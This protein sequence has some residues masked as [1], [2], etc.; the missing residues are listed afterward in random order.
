V[1]LRG[2]GA[3]GREV[4]HARAELVLMPQLPAAP[5]GVLEV[6]TRPYPH[7]QTD[8]YPG[9]LFHGADLQGIE[10]VEGCATEGVVGRVA[11]AP[12]P[13][14]WIRQPLRPNWLADPLAL[15]S[16]FQLMVVWSRAAHG[17]PSLPCFAGEYRQYRRSFPRGGVR[18]VCRVTLNH[19][20]RAQ[21]DIDFVDPSGALVARMRDYECTLDGSLTEAFRRHQLP[22]LALPTT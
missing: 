19:P 14:A 17:V 1:E 10:L 22:Q 4:L 8:L 18:V 6:A 20:H 16:A 15:D 13:A 7:T 21:A 9:L 11:T 5:Q 2:Q 12:A 3:N